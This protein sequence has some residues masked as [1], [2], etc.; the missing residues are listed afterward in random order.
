MNMRKILTY[1]L[2]V[3]MAAVLAQSASAYFGCIIGTK[4]A[5]CFNKGL[6]SILGNDTTIFNVYQ[7]DLS[8]LGF[9]AERAEIKFTVYNPNNVTVG[10]K[11]GINGKWYQTIYNIEPGETVTIKSNVWLEDLKFGQRNEIAFKTTVE[12]SEELPIKGHLLVKWSKEE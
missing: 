7:A 12:V 8:K 4:N 5:V 3:V 2:L 10:V 11:Y 1:G 9:E 6:S